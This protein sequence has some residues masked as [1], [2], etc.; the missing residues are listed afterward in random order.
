MRYPEFFT[1]LEPVPGAV[2]GMHQLQ[3]DGHELIIATK[4]PK[5][6]GHAFHGKLSWVRKHLPFFNTDNFVAVQRKDLLDGDILLDD[7]PSNI[8]LFQE[9]KRLVVAFD[10]PWNRNIKSVRVKTWEE[11]VNFMRK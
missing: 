1:D 6:A 2:E 4:C 10:K 5:S 9:K 7:S 3:K 8:K 11:F